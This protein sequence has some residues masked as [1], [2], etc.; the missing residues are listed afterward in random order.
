MIEQGHGGVQH[1]QLI[2]DGW[3]VGV[4]HVVVS[5]QF[6]RGTDVLHEDLPLDAL[7]GCGLKD[8]PTT[9][10]SV[11]GHVRIAAS[12]RRAVCVVVSLCPL[13]RDSPAVAANNLQLLEAFEPGRPSVSRLIGHGITG[14]DDGEVPFIGHDQLTTPLSVVR[15]EDLF[16]EVIGPETLCCCLF[17][18]VSTDPNDEVR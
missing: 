18:Y 3:E 2:I 8:E 7:A 12:P 16:D 15:V 9:N 6:S 11:V 5:R 10:G 14:A 1:Q 13:N 4:Q 17:T